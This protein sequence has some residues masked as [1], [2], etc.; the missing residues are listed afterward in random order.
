MTKVL[1]AAL[2]AALSLIWTVRPAHADGNLNNVKHI[3]VLIQENH[4]FDNYFGA[5]AYAPGSPYHNG[6]G[7]CS[8]TDHQCIDGLSCTLS[9]GNLACSNSNVNNQG[10][11][12]YASH[13]NT[14]CITDPDHSW[15]GEHVD[16]NFEDPNDALKDTVNKWV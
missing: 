14:R 6:N 13:S 1:R 16:L 5:L 3:I 10:A 8:A 11:W 12:V 4:S 2:L 9:A 15:Y 7:S